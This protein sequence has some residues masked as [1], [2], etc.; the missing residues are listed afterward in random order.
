MNLNHLKLKY[1]ESILKI[2]KSIKFNSEG[3]VICD[4]WRFYMQNICAS[5]DASRLRRGSLKF[6]FGTLSSALRRGSLKFL[7]GTLSSAPSLFYRGL[8]LKALTNLLICLPIFTLNLNTN[9]IFILFQLPLYF[10]FH[11]TAAFCLSKF[12]KF[13]KLVLHFFKF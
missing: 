10:S 9:S 13:T 1:R 2:R 8:T 7:F 5:L 12:M 4:G 3:T 6:L 11:R